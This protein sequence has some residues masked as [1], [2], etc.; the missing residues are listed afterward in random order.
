MSRPVLGY[1]WLFECYQYSPLHNYYVVR[2]FSSA[3][4]SSTPK[5]VS[6]NEEIYPHE[7]IEHSEQFFT[8]LVKTLY[9]LRKNMDRA[10]KIPELQTWF[11]VFAPQ[12]LFMVG[13]GGFR[14]P[15]FRFSLS[16]LICP[17]LKNKIYSVGERF[18]IPFLTLDGHNTKSLF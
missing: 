2:R 18:I 6:K 15:P 12:S 5:T 1:V 11:W 3:T 4:I 9:S 17:K 16:S 13:E 14:W 7:L 8:D 10:S